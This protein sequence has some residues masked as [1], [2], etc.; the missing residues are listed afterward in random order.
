MRIYVAGHQGLVGSAI[1]KQ[2]E[3]DQKHEWIGKTRAELNLLDNHS[4]LNYLKMEKPDAIILAAAKVGGIKAN[5]D[6]PV[7]FLSQ[8]LQIQL[9][10]INAAHEIEIDKFVFLGSSCIYPKMSPQ[11]IKEEYLLTGLLEPTNEPYAIAKI[12]GLK[13]IEAYRK[14]FDRKWISVMP[15]N[16]YGPRDNFDLKSSHVMPALIRKF[17]EAKTQQSESIKL[18]GSGEPRRE[19]LYSEDLANAILF[20]LE[21]YDDDKIVNI[22]TG[23]DIAI[24]E[25][26]NLISEII[27][28]EGEISWDK[29]MP[30]GTPRKLLDVSRLNNLGWHAQTSLD[31]GIAKTYDWF[32][33]NFFGIN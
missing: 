12:A 22:G 18:W 30:D 14:E 16:I 20:L 21:N 8:N 6:F 10:I 19:F 32:L 15:T 11:P 1:V 5:K 13:L 25:L 9:N 7:E 33:K 17:H 3:S 4:V 2:I 26:A 31:N 29:D 27:G 24:C 28:F 23:K